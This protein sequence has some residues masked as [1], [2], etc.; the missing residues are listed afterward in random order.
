MSTVGMQ[1]VTKAL[2]N[3]LSDENLR[4]VSNS[5]ELCFAILNN[6]Y[7][8]GKNTEESYLCLSMNDLS[9]VKMVVF[10]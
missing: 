9:A 2:L 6:N 1:K 3:S 8:K 10:N 4:K 5:S 7:Q